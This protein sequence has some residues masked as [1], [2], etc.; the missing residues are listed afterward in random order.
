MLNFLPFDVGFD[1]V[2]PDI[3][4]ISRKPNEKLN[5]SDHSAQYASILT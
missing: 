4:K 3:Y 1:L 2:Q 5:S